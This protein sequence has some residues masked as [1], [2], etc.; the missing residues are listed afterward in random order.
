M[1]IDITLSI[2]DLANEII[3]ND[4]DYADHADLPEG[5]SLA[6]YPDGVWIIDHRPTVDMALYPKIYQVIRAPLWGS[7]LIEC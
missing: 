7:N 2:N 1:Q 4:W 3:A 5:F 6:A